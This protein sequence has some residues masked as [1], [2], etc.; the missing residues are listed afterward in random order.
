MTIF[1]LTPNKVFLEEHEYSD[2]HFHH[3]DDP[4]SKMQEVTWTGASRRFKIVNG[5]VLA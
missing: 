1:W 3:K 5:T 4:R 2:K